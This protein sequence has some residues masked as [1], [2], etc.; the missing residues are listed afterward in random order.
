MNSNLP[1]WKTLYD[2]VS[3]S[4]NKKQKGATKNAPVVTTPEEAENASFEIDSTQQM[5]V[6]QSLRL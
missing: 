1:K 2:E 3:E 5:N 4:E 6:P